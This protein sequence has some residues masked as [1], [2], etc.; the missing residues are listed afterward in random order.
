MRNCAAARA[1]YSPQARFGTIRS[2]GLGWRSAPRPNGLGR[3]RA[4]SGRR[5]VRRRPREPPTL[6]P[7]RARTPAARLARFGTLLPARCSFPTALGNPRTAASDTNACAWP[8]SCL[9]LRAAGPAPK[10]SSICAVSLV[11]P[12]RAQGR[13][14]RSHISWKAGPPGFSAAPAGGAPAS[15]GIQASTFARSS[16]L[17]NGLSIW[18]L[19]PAA[20]SD[21]SSPEKAMMGIVDRGPSSARIR[22]VAAAPVMTG[23]WASIRMRSKSASSSAARAS[24]P[25]PARATSYPARTRIFCVKSRTAS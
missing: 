15:Q 11:R 10:A 3:R 18:S 19:T 20:P 7:W 17:V 23:I 9:S 12:R 16:A 21:C 4:N 2:E 1:G 14:I 6:Q 8:T 25:L 22:R 24:A 5:S 13:P